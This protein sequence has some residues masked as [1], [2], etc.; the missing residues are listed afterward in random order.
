MRGGARA[1]AG[2]PKGRANKVTA[3]I[4][5]LAREY[6][7]AIMPALLSIATKGESEAARVSAIKEILDRAYGKSPQALTG[8]DGGPIKQA[9]QIISG[10]PRADD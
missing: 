2:R 4:K 1:N 3:E 5:E 7:P 8:E 10:V 9:I 6:V